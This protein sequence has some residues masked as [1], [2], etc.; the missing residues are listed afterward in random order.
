M[1]V[2]IQNIHF[3]ASQ[4]LV[5]FINT[6]ANRFARRYPTLEYVDFKLTLIKPQTAHNKEARIKALIP[7]NGELTAA[8]T[9]DT[10][11]EAVTLALEAID[12]QLEKIKDRM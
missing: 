2:R 1:E 12:V 6:K 8:K 3:D 7:H 5:D 11:E 4:K 9:A 10:F